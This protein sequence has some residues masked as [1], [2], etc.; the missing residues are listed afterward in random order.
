MTPRPLWTACGKVKR[1]RMSPGK[2]KGWPSTV[3]PHDTRGIK[4]ASAFAR[5][6]KRSLAGSRLRDVCAKRATGDWIGSRR[7]S[8]WQPPPTTWFACEIYSGGCDPKAKEGL[9]EA[10]TA[11]ISPRKTAGTLGTNETL[12]VKEQK[13]RLERNQAGSRLVFQQPLNCCSIN[14]E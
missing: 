9:G 14:F 6:S 10:T 1:P 11:K 7:C 3:E 5:A 8:H 12:I 4:P 13:I 2:P